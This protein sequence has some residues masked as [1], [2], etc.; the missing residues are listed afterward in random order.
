MTTTPHPAQHSGAP[1]VP[2]A[3][4]PPSTFHL[5]SNFP[6]LEREEAG[7]KVAYF[8]GP[9]GTQVPRQVVDAMADYLLY[10]NANTHWAY[11]SSA[12]TDA[13]LLAARGAV[14]DF[15]NAS[16]T[17]VAFAN[18]MTT[19]TFH[20][21]RALGR[22][23]GPGDE[24]VITDLDHHA[25]VAPW[26]ALEKERG[27]T[28]RRVKVDLRTGEIDL[29]SLR[30]AITGRTRLLAIGAGSNALGTLT[31]VAAAGQLAHRAGALVFVDAVHAAPH[32]LVDVKTIDCDFLGCSAY[33][34][35]GPHA[36]V[37]FAREALLT[38]LDLPKLEPAPEAAPE[39]FETGTQ[40]HEGIVGTGAAIDFLASLGRGASRR[41][42]LEDSYR[43][44]HHAGAALFERMWEGI[45]AIPGV[46]RY[47]PTPD[48]PRTP[49]LAFTVTGIGSEAV[50]KALAKRG[51]FV[52]HGDFYAATIVAQL[53]HA[54]AGLVRAGVACYTT[55]DEVDRLLAGVREVLRTG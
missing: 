55:A 32:A 13:M 9:G 2:G 28:I 5:R 41:A 37:I 49:T 25:N 39:R 29:A 31:D 43:T 1:A 42:R 44:L 23:W 15:L 53:G 48:R 18:N 22:A 54:A 4:L 46:T 8:D 16:P 45:G 52:S 24:V 20:L 40:N 26:R 12:E 50:A 35:Y 6:A 14:A 10:H 11:P 33:K 38:A 36:G 21:A 27:I 17:E 47:G 7:V 19:G 30:E 34:F 3:P 51:V